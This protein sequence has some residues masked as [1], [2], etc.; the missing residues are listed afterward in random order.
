M[1]C[2]TVLEFMKL[3]QC[4]NA[5]KVGKANDPKKET[6]HGKELWPANE[7]DS[8]VD[9]AILQ[10]V[11]CWFHNWRTDSDNYRGAA[12][13]SYYTRCC[14]SAFKKI[15]DNW[16]VYQESKRQD[17]L[18][19]VR[20]GLYLMKQ[21]WLFVF[22]LPVRIIKFVMGNWIPFLGISHDSAYRVHPYYFS[23]IKK[24]KPSHCDS[25]SISHMVTFCSDL[26]I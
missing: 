15:R 22:K 5:W 25:V 26:A 2:Q 10:P 24:L 17:N 7:G 6:L 1:V 18:C 20:D 9:G 21:Q 23:I 8:L 3:R 4:E 13:M 14:D 16:A 19:T 12:I 11:P